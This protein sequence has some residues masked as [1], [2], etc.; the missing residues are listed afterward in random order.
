[1][2]E[3]YGEDA[4]DTI[5]FFNLMQQISAKLVRMIRESASL[6]IKVDPNAKGSYNEYR[7]K[8]YRQW[9]EENNYG[10]RAW[11]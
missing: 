8:G 5:G 6:I 10:M 11:Y 3:F 7:K 9:A 1:M 2:T 4:F